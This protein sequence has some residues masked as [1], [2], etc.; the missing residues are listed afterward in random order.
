MMV[1]F[2]GQI[3]STPLAPVS[4]AKSAI[5]DVLLWLESDFRRRHGDLPGRW[6]LAVRRAAHAVAGALRLDTERRQILAPLLFS[7]V[8]QAV[9]FAVRVGD[10]RGRLALFAVAHVLHGQ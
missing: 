2:S 7:V 1:A 4:S 9:F 10:E 5:A 8:D 6:P 3:G